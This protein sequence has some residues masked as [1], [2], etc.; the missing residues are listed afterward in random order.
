M[1]GRAGVSIAERKK[2]LEQNCEID[3]DRP[4]S[5]KCTQGSGRVPPRDA[6]EGAS[7]VVRV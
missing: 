1:L 7:A 3:T 5:G 4:V 6:T 2:T